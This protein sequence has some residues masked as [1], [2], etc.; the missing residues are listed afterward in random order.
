M[1]ESPFTTPLMQCRS[2][3]KAA[4]GHGRYCNP[5]LD[6][7]LIGLTILASILIAID[8]TLWMLS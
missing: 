5:V 2:C 3:G 6:R 4:E 8:Y 7:V 1:N